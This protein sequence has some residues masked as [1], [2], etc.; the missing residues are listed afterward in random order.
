MYV[1]F[2]HGK[3]W[4]V[5]IS[6]FC[7]NHWVVLGAGHGKRDTTRGLRFFL[8]LNIVCSDF[9]SSSLQPHSDAAGS[10]NVIRG[11]DQW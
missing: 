9:F 7:L 5:M 1:R 11:S 3:L 8:D 6:P 4:L 2:S 10:D